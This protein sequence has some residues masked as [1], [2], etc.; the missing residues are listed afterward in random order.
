MNTMALINPLHLIIGRRFHGKAL[1]FSQDLRQK[2]IE[3]LC[4]GAQNHLLF[5]HKDSPSSSQIFLQCPSQ[6]KLPLHFG[7]FQNLLLILA[8]GSPHRFGNGGIGHLLPGNSS[9]PLEKIDK[10]GFLFLIGNRKNISLLVGNK[11]TASFLP[12][13]IPFLLQKCQRMF[14]C[15]QGNAPF[16][17]KIALGGKAFRE[18]VAAFHNILP[19]FPVKLHVLFHPSLLSLA[20][21]S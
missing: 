17:G 14:H 2:G 19:H 18:A 1:F 7:G 21:S 5:L 3:I 20:V 4:S 10:T 8:H 6:K 11:V 13:N 12:L 15:N 9:F 16:L